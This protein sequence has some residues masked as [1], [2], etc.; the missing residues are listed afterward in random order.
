[1]QKFPTDY[2]VVDNDV[3]KTFAL[4]VSSFSREFP[5]R[6]VDA[7]GWWLFNAP[8]IRA[9]VKGQKQFDFTTDEKNATPCRNQEVN[10]YDCRCVQLS[11]NENDP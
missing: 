11:L 4:N 9:R 3:R 6:R 10:D 5:E 7:E 8:V 1:M 2:Y